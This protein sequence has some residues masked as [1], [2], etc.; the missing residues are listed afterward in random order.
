MKFKNITSEDICLAGVPRIKAGETYET[1][2]ELQIRV[3]ANSELVEPLGSVEKKPC[4][5]C[6]KPKLSKKSSSKADS[7]KLVD[8]DDEDK[9]TFN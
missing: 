1:E 4:K 2:S 9:K 3:L 6:A 5:G 8:T 7:K